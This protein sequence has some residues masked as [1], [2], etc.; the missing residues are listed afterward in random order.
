MFFKPITLPVQE[1]RPLFYPC[2]IA[3]CKSSRIRQSHIRCEY[4]VKLH[5][6]RPDMIV[7][8]KIKFDYS[9]CY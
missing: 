2:P 7:N 4:I 3:V 6:F 1:T 5:I 9:T 8:G